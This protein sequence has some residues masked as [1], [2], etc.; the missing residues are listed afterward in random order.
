MSESENL[1]HRAATFSKAFLARF[2]VRSESEPIDS[3]ERLFEFVATR[4]AFVAQKTLYGYLKTRI[5]T[6]YP[7]MFEDDI[8][9]QSINIAKI[10]VFTACLSDLTIYSVALALA[11]TED[12]TVKRDTA[13]ACF[14][15]GFERNSDGMPE[16]FDPTE[17]LAA[18]E[19]RMEDLDWTG[20]ASSRDVFSTSPKALCD[21]APIAPR[22]KKYDTE[23]IENSVILNWFEIRERFRKRLRAAPIRDEILSSRQA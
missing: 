12:S 18:F 7:T 3:R 22:H 1:L 17:A 9:V 21:W 5:G 6:R 13:R 2:R 10:N 4:A 19:S 8:F 16:D 14:E 23:I 20:T 15:D 11:D